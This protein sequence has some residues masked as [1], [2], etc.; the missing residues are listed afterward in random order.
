M[1]YTKWGCLDELKCRDHG[2]DET[3][4]GWQIWMPW[5]GLLLACKDSIV[6]MTNFL[7]NLARSRTKHMRQECVGTKI[8]DS[9]KSNA[10]IDPRCGPTHKKT[11]KGKKNPKIDRLWPPQ[12]GS[13]P[14]SWSFSLD[15]PALASF[16]EAFDF[17][18]R[19]DLFFHCS[20]LKSIH[21]ARKSPWSIYIVRD[22]GLVYLTL[23]GEWSCFL[24]R[25]RLASTEL[26]LPHPIHYS[27][28]RLSRA[29]RHP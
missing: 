8:L 21:G 5:L 1:L 16:M 20:F 6:T 12:L 26:A 9:F 28:W 4:L 19:F 27:I 11:K 22:L 3:R 18:R 13:L 7:F 14:R 2:I 29:P 25:V 23:R 24:V 15:G 10:K 17:L